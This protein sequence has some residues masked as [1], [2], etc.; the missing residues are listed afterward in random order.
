M[1]INMIEVTKEGKEINRQKNQSTYYAEEC[2]GRDWLIMV[3][4]VAI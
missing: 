1:K 2:L 3:G 4:L